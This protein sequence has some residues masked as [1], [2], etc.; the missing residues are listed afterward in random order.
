M[1][2]LSV[3]FNYIVW[4]YHTVRFQVVWLYVVIIIALLLLLDLNNVDCGTMVLETL[5]FDF[6]TTQ[7]QVYNSM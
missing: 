4:L 1:P 5:P 6:F 3:I 7:Q 2:K